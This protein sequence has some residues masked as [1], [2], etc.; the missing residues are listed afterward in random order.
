VQTLTTPVRSRNL[1]LDVTRHRL[2]VAAATFAAPPAD[3]RG[4]GPMI[5]GSFA[6]LEIGR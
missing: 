5:P 1:G 2:Y 6:L 3:G 4:R